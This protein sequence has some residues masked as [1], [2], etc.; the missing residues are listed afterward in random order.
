MWEHRPL[1]E[2]WPP[3][4]EEEGREREREKERKRTLGYGENLNW[5]LIREPLGTSWL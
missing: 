3:L 1:Q 5:N 2:L 4:L